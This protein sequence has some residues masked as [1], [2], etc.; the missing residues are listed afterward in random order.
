MKTLLFNAKRINEN[1]QSTATLVSRGRK[2]P[3]HFFPRISG[4]CYDLV[5][6][7][8]RVLPQSELQLVF[9]ATSLFGRVSTDSNSIQELIL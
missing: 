2:E 3:A 4:I 5:N 8:V 9:E 7:F 1:L 6:Q